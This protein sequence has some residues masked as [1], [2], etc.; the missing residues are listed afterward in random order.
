MVEVYA[1]VTD[2]HGRQVPG[3]K[4]DQFEVIEDGTQQRIQLFEPYTSALTVALL[5]DTTGS[6]T[7]ELPFVKNAVSKLLA[8]MKPQDSFG[9]FSF[10]DR[11]T[12]L[13]PFTQDRQ[14]ATRALLRT[15]A[16]G[17]TALFDALTQLA[18]ELSR[19]TGKKAILLF[20]DGDDNSSLLTRENAIRNIKRIGIP[21][22]AVAQGEALGNKTLR[23]CL[24]EISEA[25]CGISY[26]VKSQD[27]LAKIFDEIG[28]DLQ[29]LYLI[30]YQ[31]P[32]ETKSDWHKITVRVRAQKGV[33]IRAKEGYWR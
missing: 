19:V 5:I 3:L 32:T 2:N 31:P 22:Y 8:L 10:S 27:D 13:Q 7:R 15:R 9:L 12:V 11:L 16:A 30:G 26:E 25:T 21:V 24:E 1:A 17:R 28:R 23:K 18:P 33:K 14:A 6:M 4:A 29:H 20:T